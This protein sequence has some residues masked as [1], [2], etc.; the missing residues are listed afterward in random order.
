MILSR[1]ALNLK[2]GGMENKMYPCAVLR[3]RP[4]AD[5]Y[6][7]TINR[8][9]RLTL[10]LPFILIFL[11]IPLS[12]PPFWVYFLSLLLLH[13]SFTLLSNNYLI[14]FFFYLCVSLFLLNFHL[15][16]KSALFP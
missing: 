15:F 6:A 4:Q 10:C 14:T 9:Q 5:K 16:H 3:R 7:G 1:D 12:F 8:N 13:L 2:R 11:F